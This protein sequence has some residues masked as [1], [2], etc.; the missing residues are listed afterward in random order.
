MSEHAKMVEEVLDSG[1]LT[2]WE[3]SFL[4]SL[5]DKLDRETPLSEREAEKLQEI[6]DERM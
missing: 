2:K 3:E 5:S 4:M 6:Y 1:N